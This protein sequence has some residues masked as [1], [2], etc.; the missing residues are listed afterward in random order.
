MN[1]QFIINPLIGAGIGYVTNWIAIKMMFR[2]TKAIK[3]GKFTLP[4][5]P[6][7]IPKNRSRLAE[8]IGNTISNNLLTEND[9]KDVLLS[10]EIKSQIQEKIEEY[11][12]SLSS[13]DM[14]L[15]DFINL[16]VEKDSYDKTITSIQSNLTKSILQTVIEANLGAIISEQ[17]EIAANEKMK[18]SFIGLIGGKSL[19]S[20]LSSNI[21]TSL[22][23]YIEE[24]GEEVI[25][26]MV[27]KEFEKYTS[28][29]V[30]Q[31]SSKLSGPD[32]NIVST[33]MNIYEKIISEK[34]TA[35]LKSLNISKIIANKINSMEV[36]ELE[37]LLLKT[38]K[39]ELDALVNLGAVIGFIL[40][41][42]NLL[43]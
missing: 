17:I 20:S 12:S 15:E 37:R 1:Y 13:K 33:I 41:F 2:P 39:K 31:L 35:A 27:K 42:L 36:L 34:I 3:I 43:V 5:T 40:G 14:T 11:I 4:F 30:V 24:N 23:K 32:N 25:S 19:V 38:I 29:N 16:Y 18:G 22:N 7:I 21:T 10:D 28:Q 9:L 26:G 6:G 8:A